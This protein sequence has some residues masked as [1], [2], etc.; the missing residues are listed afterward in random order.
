[1]NP[2]KSL[3]RIPVPW[4]FIIAYLFG[5]ALQYIIP[6]NIYSNVPLQSIKHIGIFLLI[7]GVMIAIWSLFFLRKR[8]ITTPTGE[9]ISSIVTGGPYRF[10]RHPMYV[11]LAIS[12][13][14][15]ALFLLHSWPILILIVIFL[16]VNYIAIPSEEAT[17]KKDFKDEYEDYSKR[18]RRWI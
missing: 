8:R 16:Y 14:G 2:T 13:I 17:L 1:M 3:L 4:I 9:K 10:S 15:V 18:T 7:I 5:I 11:S 12:Y 6:I